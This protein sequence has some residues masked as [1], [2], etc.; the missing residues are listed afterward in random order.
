MRS[1]GDPPSQSLRMVPPGTPT[2]RRRSHWLSGAETVAVRHLPPLYAPVIN[3]NYTIRSR[4]QKLTLPG[5]FLYYLI[6]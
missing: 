5:I 3:K 4:Q 1:R 6:P 2:T